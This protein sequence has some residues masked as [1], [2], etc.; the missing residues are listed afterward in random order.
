VRRTAFIQ[1][2]YTELTPVAVAAGVNS[3][4]PDGHIRKSKE[5]LFSSQKNIPSQPPASPFSNT[6]TE[7]AT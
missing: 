6:S 3:F 4:G 1:E 5:M 7:M 2:F